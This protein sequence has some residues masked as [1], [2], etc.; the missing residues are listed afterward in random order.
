MVARLPSPELVPGS[1]ESGTEAGNAAAMTARPHPGT[2]PVSTQDQ[3]STSMPN[4]STTWQ[5]TPSAGAA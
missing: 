1:E 2:I 4:G 3:P 5:K